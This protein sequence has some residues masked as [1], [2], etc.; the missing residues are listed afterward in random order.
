[1]SVRRLVVLGALAAAAVVVYR[2]ITAD[3]G[4]SFDPSSAAAGLR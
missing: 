4:G 1:M 2:K 3:K